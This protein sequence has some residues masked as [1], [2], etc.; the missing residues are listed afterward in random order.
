MCSCLLPNLRLTSINELSSLPQQK[1]MVPHSSAR[2][3][4]TFQHLLAERSYH[5]RHSG[6]A[7]STQ[8]EPEPEHS[9]RTFQTPQQPRP[10][11]RGG[12]SP[13]RLPHLI[14]SQTQHAF[15]ST[16]QQDVQLNPS[17][18][19][20]RISEHACPLEVAKISDSERKI[21]QAT[22]HRYYS[23]RGC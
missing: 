9:P 11:K 21:K 6:K 13:I 8:Y 1:S 18:G 2:L 5:K 4:S 10:Q 19:E 15:L 23:K 17:E 12:R 14:N 7:L 3:P 22:C 16:E 20:K